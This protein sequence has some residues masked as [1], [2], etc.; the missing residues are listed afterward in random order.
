MDRRGRH[1]GGYHAARAVGLRPCEYATWLV[2]PESRSGPVDGRHDHVLAR[3]IEGMRRIRSFGEVDS[4]Y[5]TLY[6]PS[7]AVSVL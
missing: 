7:F 2:V 6:L 1:V 5:L 3:L 4:M